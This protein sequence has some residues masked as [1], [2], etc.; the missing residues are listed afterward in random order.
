MT[1]GLQVAPPP[2]DLKEAAETLFSSS[3]KSFLAKAL[4]R[5]EPEVHSTGETG[6]KVF[7]L[8]GM[9]VEGKED[10]EARF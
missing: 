9:Y 6:F 5:W 3:A 8:G 7:F 10:Q 2:D 4:E 1:Q